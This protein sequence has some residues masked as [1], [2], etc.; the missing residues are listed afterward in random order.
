MRHT[1]HSYLVTSIVYYNTTEVCYCIVW[2][3]CRKQVNCFMCQVL[4]LSFRRSLNLAKC[5]DWSS[6]IFH[7]L[8]MTDV[9]FLWRVSFRG[10]MCILVKAD[11]SFYLTDNFQWPTF[12]DVFTYNSN[13]SKMINNED[14]LY[15]RINLRNVLYCQRNWNLC[16]MVS[17]KV[18]KMV[19]KCIEIMRVKFK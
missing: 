15:P 16:D 14:K 9:T 12:K 6:Y 19:L 1:F 17:L 2:L 7:V 11:G 4:T 3:G 5:Q 18:C 10:F 13:I 8:K